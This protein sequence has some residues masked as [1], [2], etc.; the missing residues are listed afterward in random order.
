MADFDPAIAFVLKHE[1]TLSADPNDPG[2]LTKYGIS[3]RSYPGLDIRNLTVDQ[4]RAIYQRDF[5]K[6]AGIKSQAVANKVLDLAVNLG[7]AAAARVLQQS[8]GSLMAGPIVADGVVGPQTIGLVNAADEQELLAELKARA[9]YYHTQ[10]VIAN[11]SS[12]S[13]LLGWLRRDVDG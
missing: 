12:R 4:A 7:S 2:G 1:G 9:A 11:P 8:L 3:T 6:Y 5:W 10:D 13:F